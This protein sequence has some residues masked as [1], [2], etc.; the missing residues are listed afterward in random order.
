MKTGT[1]T[2]DEID[3]VGRLTLIWETGEKETV[4]HAEP[5]KAGSDSHTIANLFGGA[6]AVEHDGAYIHI[7]RSPSPPRTGWRR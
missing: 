1:I 2:W 6:E 4:E 3:G 7:T 5:I